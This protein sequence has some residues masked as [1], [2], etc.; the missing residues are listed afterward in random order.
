MNTINLTR[1][2]AS[3]CCFHMDKEEDRADRDLCICFVLTYLSTTEAANLFD[4]YKH[5]ASMNICLLFD[6]LFQFVYKSF[7]K[8]LEIVVTCSAC[9]C[10]KQECQRKLTT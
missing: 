10:L 8:V 3:Q 6:G 2:P 5:A 7:V 4:Q 1:V 9:S